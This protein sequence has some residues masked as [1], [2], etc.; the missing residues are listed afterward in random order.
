MWW[1]WWQYVATKIYL[2]VSHVTCYYW[3]HY[4]EDS[5]YAYTLFI[6]LCKLTI[7]TYCTVLF[8]VKSFNS[9]T[10]QSCTESALKCNLRASILK[11]SWGHT[12]RPPSIS[13][14]CML[15]VFHTILTRKSH[16][17]IANKFKLVIS[18]WPLKFWVLQPCI[19]TQI[20]IDKDKKNGDSLVT[21]LHFKAIMEFSK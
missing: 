10:C 2:L 14:F 13:M 20:S 5:T 1:V 6:L 3:S 9:W 18:T 15:I 8:M 17:Y 19:L 7:V 12:P 4:I 21:C 11:F 16:S